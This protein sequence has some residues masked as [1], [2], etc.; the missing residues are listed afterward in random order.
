MH[1]LISYQTIVAAKN[2]DSIA[3]SA[4][5]RH[6]AY[7]INY[8]SRRTYVDTFGNHHGIVN[9][10]I[11][12]RIEAKL[13]FQII[14]R[15]DPTRLPQKKIENREMCPKLGRISCGYHTAQAHSPCAFVRADIRL[16]LYAVT[17]TE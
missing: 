10:E 9:E 17:T 4:I 16:G 13:M 1:R 15:F 3:M 7:Y 14:D 11:K 2:G 5:L 6:Y 8:Y 12:Q